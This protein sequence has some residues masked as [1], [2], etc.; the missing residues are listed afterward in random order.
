MVNFLTEKIRNLFGNNFL[1]AILTLFLVAYASLAR[2][3]LP[4]FIA[5]LFESGFFRLLILFLVAYTSSQNSNI[6]LLI[7]VVFVVT[8]NLLN[9]Q[10][11]FE[12]FMTGY[13][14]S[15]S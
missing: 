14:N 11:M 1:G 3:Q 8:M 15:D 7:A 10:R 12:G 13:M 2:P 5:Q 9:E 4:N 6:A